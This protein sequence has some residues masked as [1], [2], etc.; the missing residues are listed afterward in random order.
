[1]HPALVHVPI[2]FL[3]GGVV[4]L[5]WAW[6]RANEIQHRVAAGMLL[7]GMVSGWLASTAGGLA[8]FTVP[9]HTEQ[10]HVLMY[11]H[12]G[13]GLAMLIL[14]TWLSTVSWRG[15]T[16]AATKLQLTVALC[17][18]VLLMLTGYL[19]GLIVYHHGAGVNPN[20]LAPEIRDGHSHG[21]NEQ[22]DVSVHEH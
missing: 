12:L 2:A 15:R 21:N 18:V 13:F 7:V 22:H 3:L 6:W 20:I 19:G 8:Y 4:L 5:L 11:W 16:T 10:G 14:F 9:A 1:M 17:G